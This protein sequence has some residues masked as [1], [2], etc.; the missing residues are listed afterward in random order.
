MKDAA[1]KKASSRIPNSFHHFLHHLDCP[2]FW[3]SQETRRKIS[4]SAY[5]CELVS[6]GTL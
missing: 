3:P 2:V 4:I 5:S 1:S 6:F